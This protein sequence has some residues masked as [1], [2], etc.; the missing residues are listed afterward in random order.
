M[1]T[2]LIKH[3]SSGTC[4]SVHPFGATITSFVNSLG[5]E[6][7]FMSRLA[8]TD[9]SKAIRGGVPLVFPQFGQPNK[10]MPQ[11]GFLRNNVW[12]VGKV[13]DEMEEAG[14]NFTLALKD[15]VNG[16]GSSSSCLW[17]K[18][19][20]TE[21]GIDCTVTLRVRVAKDQLK[22]D[23]IIRNTGSSCF[24][25]QAL[26][27]TYF[28]IAG[29]KALDK[30]VCHVKGLG[31]Y[32]VE[33]K[34][35]GESYIQSESEVVHVDREVDRIYCPPTT[36][37]QKEC[38]SDVIVN[39]VSSSSLKVQI[40]TGTDG[41]KVD[42]KANAMIMLDDDDDN[43]TKKEP[44]PVSVVVWNPYVDK[45]KAMSDFGDDQYHDMICV[46]P[47]LTH[48]PTIQAQ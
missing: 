18:E 17:S 8:K 29:R 34:I 36:I 47:L 23:L 33:D 30:K 4:V 6:I 41:S 24:P 38:D 35:T 16:R 13:F 9:G 28:K 27:H 40:C 15:V 45:A 22:C 26:F 43:E 21:M 32:S 46:E 25:C 42:L 11:H 3:S 7:L 2:V 19:K 12:K 14:C 39:G 44:L 37:T 5:R 10:D 1:E 48:N 20:E 31:G